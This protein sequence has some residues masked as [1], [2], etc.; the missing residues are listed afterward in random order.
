MVRASVRACVYEWCACGCVCLCACVNICV[1]ARTLVYVRALLVLACLPCTLN[2]HTRTSHTQHRGQTVAELIN[3]SRTRT[4]CPNGKI[5]KNLCGFASSDPLVTP[6]I[7][8]TQPAPA[9][10]FFCLCVCA[11][12]ATV[13]SDDSHMRPPR[14][15][16]ARAEPHV[17]AN[18]RRH[19]HA[20]ART[21][22][23]LADGSVRV[24]DKKN[25]ILTLETLVRT[26]ERAAASRY[27]MSESV[28]V[29]VCV[30]VCLCVCARAWTCV[31]ACERVCERVWRGGWMVRACNH[32]NHGQTR[33][34]HT[35][36]YG[37]SML[38]HTQAQGRGRQCCCCCGA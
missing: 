28:S 8:A 15:M 13:F 36:Q 31:C 35:H 9:G 33:W 18:P 25:G 5:L 10:P 24:A 1:F 6:V 16:H 17:Y 12:C 23:G 11:C 34:Q 7:A 37:Y 26:A 14:T 4:P 19:T 38:S 27:C 29:C 21:G 32:M 3:Q 20:H 2:A 30:F 22:V